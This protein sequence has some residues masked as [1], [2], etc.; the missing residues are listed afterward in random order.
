MGCNIYGGTVDGPA[1]GAAIT[2]NIFTYDY[3]VMDGLALKASY[4][5][6]HTTG[7]VES[8]IDYGVKYTGIEGLTVICCNG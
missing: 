2:H 3:T 1:N 7:A 8:S 6:S 4:V 5:P